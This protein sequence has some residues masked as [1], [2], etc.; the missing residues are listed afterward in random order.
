M[1]NLLIEPMASRNAR[2]YSESLI[3][4]V[5]DAPL[6]QGYQWAKISPGQTPKDFFEKKNLARGR[7]FFVSQSLN[8]SNLLKLFSFYLK[9]EATNNN[10]KFIIVSRGG[11]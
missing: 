8:L 3:S 5:S 11:V 9:K 10:F 2:I 7:Q 4:E 1:I 6:I